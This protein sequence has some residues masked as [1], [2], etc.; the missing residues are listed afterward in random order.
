MRRGLLIVVLLLLLVGSSWAQAFDTS[1]ASESYTAKVT[2][3][4]GQPVKGSNRVRI[5]IVD[6]SSRLVEDARVEVEYL[7]PSLPGKPPMM[8]YRTSTRKAKSGYETT[9]KLDMTGEWKIVLSITRANR[10]EKITMG[11]VVR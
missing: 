10:A 11:F 9:L 5:D 8:D 7:M 2:F 1:A 3:L 4:G 6:T